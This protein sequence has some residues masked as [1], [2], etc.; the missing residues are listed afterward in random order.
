MSFCAIGFVFAIWSK[1]E[2]EGRLGPPWQCH[3]CVVNDVLSDRKSSNHRRL[4]SIRRGLIDA[5]PKY[6]SGGAL[7]ASIKNVTFLEETQ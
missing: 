3:S 2:R 4:S 1:G 5:A 6:D 7:H